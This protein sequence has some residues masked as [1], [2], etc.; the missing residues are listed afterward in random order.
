MSNSIFFEIEIILDFFLWKDFHDHVTYSSYLN[1]F[2][3]DILW[4][5]SGII[6]DF[7]QDIFQTIYGE[8]ILKFFQNDFQRKSMAK[9]GNFL[10]KIFQL[11]SL[12][13]TWIFLKKKIRTS[14]QINVNFFKLYF[15]RNFWQITWIF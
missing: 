10:K 1:F 14:R 8:I 9:F 3:N 4:N 12:K 2:P 15:L 5:N 7:L 13:L 11:D 6:Q